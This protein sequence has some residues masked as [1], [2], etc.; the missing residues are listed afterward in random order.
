MWC[1]MPLPLKYDLYPISGQ[2]SSILGSN[3]HVDLEALL[4]QMYPQSRAN[5]MHS[6]RS[7]P[8]Q[9]TAL[10]MLLEPATAKP[11]KIRCPQ[12]MEVQWVLGVFNA[13]LT[14]PISQNDVAVTVTYIALHSD[15]SFL[16]EDRKFGSKMRS[17]QCKESLIRDSQRAQAGPFSQGR[18]AAESGH[19]LTRWVVARSACTDPAA[20]AHTGG[21]REPTAIGLLQGKAAGRG[22][23]PP[24][25]WFY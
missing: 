4:Y 12:N 5:P 15:F 17:S 22:H 16:Q 20:P 6:G 3:W 14:C 1:R 11:A 10:N 7:D 25:G 18:T 24:P 21:H 2:K 9:I 8:I 23:N 13:V 19:C